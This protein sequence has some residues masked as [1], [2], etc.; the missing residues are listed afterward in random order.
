VGELL[1]A[2]ANVAVW[3]AVIVLVG[4]VLQLVFGVQV[5]GLAGLVGVLV[6]VA[7][8]RVFSNSGLRGLIATVAALLA[9]AIVI[10]MAM[11]LGADR[12]DRPEDE[13]PPDD[14]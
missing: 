2:V 9:V 10:G 11:T 8:V 1:D 4:W 14:S 6:I 12:P 7:G 3:V 13:R 5:F